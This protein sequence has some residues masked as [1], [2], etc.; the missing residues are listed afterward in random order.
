MS[1][2]QN[3]HVTVSPVRGYEF[4]VTKSVHHGIP[5]TVTVKA[6]AETAAG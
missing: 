1:K 2:A 6:R 4:I 5:A 3:H